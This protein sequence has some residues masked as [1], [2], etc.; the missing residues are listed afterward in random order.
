MAKNPPNKAR[1]A[2]AIPGREGPL[3]EGVAPPPALLPR[4]SQGQ[5]SL[6][7]HGPW[8]HQE[9]DLT[10]STCPASIPRVTQA[11]FSMST[12]TQM[13][14]GRHFLEVLKVSVQGVRRLF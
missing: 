14:Q 9:S 3:E 8:G 5:R 1:E 6:A 4:E 12:E 2:D 13:R 7:G 10:E 11:P